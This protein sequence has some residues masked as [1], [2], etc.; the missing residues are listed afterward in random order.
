MFSTLFIGVTMRKT[1]ILRIVVDM[2]LWMNQPT[3]LRFCVS[4][5]AL[6]LEK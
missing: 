2:C 3:P 6:S 4:K 5:N 1:C